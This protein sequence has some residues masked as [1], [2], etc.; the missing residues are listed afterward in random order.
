MLFLRVGNKDSLPIKW[1]LNYS[2]CTWRCIFSVNL[3]QDSVKR[4]R[5]MWKYVY[6]L[7]IRKYIKTTVSESVLL[8]YY[9]PESCCGVSRKIYYILFPSQ[10][11]KLLSETVT[12]SYNKY[13]TC[14]GSIKTILMLFQLVNWS[15]RR[16]CIKSSAVMKLYNPLCEYE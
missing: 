3:L 14:F 13:A 4:K 9:I 16:Y 6:L 1:Q 2:F 11:T 15:R 12:K 5:S 8:M 7:T 10:T